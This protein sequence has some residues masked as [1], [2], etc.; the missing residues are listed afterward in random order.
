MRTLTHYEV[1]WNM[2]RAGSTIDQITQV[3]GSLMS[4]N[5]RTLIDA[6]LEKKKRLLCRQLAKSMARK[7]T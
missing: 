6:P 1:A 4:P 5:K 3:V 7:V 2:H